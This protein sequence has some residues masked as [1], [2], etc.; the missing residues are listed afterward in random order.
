MKCE[1]LLRGAMRRLASVPLSTRRRLGGATPLRLAH[2]WGV[3][4]VDVDSRA[5]AFA[6][7][8]LTIAMW[9]VP[10]GWLFAAVAVAGMGI[11]WRRDRIAAEAE[12]M[13]L[14]AHVKTLV[15]EL[16]RQQTAQAEAHEQISHLQNRCEELTAE[17]RAVV[18]ELISAEEKAA[19]PS[20]SEVLMRRRIAQLADQLAGQVAVAIAEAEPAVNG[21]INSFSAISSDTL[22][23]AERAQMSLGIDESTGVTKVIGAA[24]EVMNNFVQTMLSTT[25][26]ITDAAEHMQT[27]TRIA[28]D[29]N[30]LLDE[31]DAVSDQT[32][33]LA[34]NASIEAARAGQAGRGFAVVAAEVRKLSDRSR[35]AAD[36]VRKLTKDITKDSQSVSR[37]LENAAE[38]SSVAGGEARLEV[39]RLMADIN[40]A[41]IHNRDLI[42]DLSQQSRNISDQIVRIIVAL[43]FHDLLRQRLEHVASPLADLRDSILYEHA[44]NIAA[45]MLPIAVGQTAPVIRSVGMAPE[46]KVVNYA[47]ESRV[48]RGPVESVSRSVSDDLDDCVTLF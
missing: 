6:V 46:L 43:Q 1:R 40:E 17:N 8:L 16:E 42:K 26:E 20:D 41:D 45:D 33:L 22:A 10:L 44:D 30:T 12:R 32:N 24:T 14:T 35:Q 27:L 11:V 38:K 39:N 2:R 7:A 25:D 36:R 18:S 47:V 3:A 23:M 34:L 37:R 9:R 13:G 31:I 4:F 28:S 15:D 29:F 21:A 5:I 19:A 48:E